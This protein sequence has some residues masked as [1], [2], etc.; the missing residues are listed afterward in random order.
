MIQARGLKK[1][2]KNRRATVEAVRGVD[3]DVAAGE[4]VGFL[5][6]NGAGK[7]TTLRMLTTL[8]EP[9]AGEATVA[10]HDLRKAAKD[11]RRSIG[12]VSQ[13]GGSAPEAIV[14]EELVFHARSYGLS[15]SDA[16]SRA[17][18][19]L[20]RLDL[21]GLQKR[22]I[23]TL[24]GGQKRRLDIAM[25]LVHSPELIFLD[26]PTTGLD[27][28]SRANLWDHIR[29]LRDEH[30]TTVF[31]TTHYLDEAD[32]MAERVMVI[33]HG[34]VIADDTPAKL[35]ADLA[36][37]RV[38][39]TLAGDGSTG[40]PEAGTV[41]EVAERLA[42]LHAFEA[43]GAVVRLRVPGGAEL[44]PA[45]LRELDHR[46]VAVRSAEVA[47]PTLDDVFLNLTGRSLREESESGQ[48]AP[49]GDGGEEGAAPGAGSTDGSGGQEVAA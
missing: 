36:G 31:L 34:R 29:K 19:L 23:K 27:P 24:S 39:L 30:G 4:V 5:G 9:T 49:A 40:T 37:D 12:Y 14:V 22:L 42:P 25:G 17:T 35:K 8:L 10:G 44:L 1:T 13:A 15:R 16:Q 48:A 2:F 26:E 20:P 32:T 3:L 38:T 18:E 28:Q 21:D 11:V 41:R 7:T 33:D 47:R 46:G 43:G 6:P 45:L